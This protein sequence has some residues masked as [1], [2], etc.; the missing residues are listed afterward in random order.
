MEIQL[1]IEPLKSIQRRADF[2]SRIRR[3]LCSALWTL[4]HK[5]WSNSADSL[6]SDYLLDNL[7]KVFKWWAIKKKK[8]KVPGLT[9]C[10]CPCVSS[11][12]QRRAVALASFASGT[13]ATSS[14]SHLWQILVEWCEERGCP[15]L[16][17][18]SHNFSKKQQ[19]ARTLPLA[20]LHREVLIWRGNCNSSSCSLNRM[21]CFFPGF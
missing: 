17:L 21:Q 15:E 6:Q 4:S 13:S 2:D 3:L 10:S 8:E 7:I 11:R 9:S 12:S 18:L 1:E 19:W 14:C 5:N 20:G 16:W